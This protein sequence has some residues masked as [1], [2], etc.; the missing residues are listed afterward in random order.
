MCFFISLLVQNTIERIRTV[1][2]TVN[3]A[4]LMFLYSGFEAQCGGSGSLQLNSFTSVIC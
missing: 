4:F 2:Q 3:K 1:D